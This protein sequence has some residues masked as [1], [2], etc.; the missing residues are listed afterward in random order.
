[1]GTCINHCNSS[2]FVTFNWVEPSILVY[3][4]VTLVGD[5]ERLKLGPDDGGLIGA[6]GVADGARLGAIAGGNGW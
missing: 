6:I 4:N 5:R 2:F 3:Y 1:M